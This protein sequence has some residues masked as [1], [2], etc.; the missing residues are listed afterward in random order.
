[1]QQRHLEPIVL[2]T[3]DVVQKHPAFFGLAHYVVVPGVVS[4]VFLHQ[5][6]HRCDF[7]RI[8][9]RAPTV[10]P[11]QPECQHGQQT[12]P[13]V[14]NREPVLPARHRIRCQGFDGLCQRGRQSRK[15]GP[16][17]IVGVA[18]RLQVV[19]RVKVVGKEVGHIREQVGR[20]NQ[21]HFVAVCSVWCQAIE[22][23]DV[24]IPFQAMEPFAQS[25][26]DQSVDAVA[27]GITDLEPGLLRH[28]SIHLGRI[29]GGK[30]AGQD[31]ALNLVGVGA[32]GQ[33]ALQNRADA[34][35]LQAGF[36]RDVD[37]QG[38]GHGFSHAGRARSVSG[39]PPAAV[40]LVTAVGPDR[41]PGGRP[42]A[43]WMAGLAKTA[44]TSPMPQHR[45]WPRTVAAMLC[46][47]HP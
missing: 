28:D 15:A 26:R 36:V 41:V 10:S 7:V 20:V 46:A 30:R 11:L 31:G 4:F 35:D 27:T 3:E 24:Q 40:Q 34:A 33:Q 44:D 39:N 9:D 42:D 16:L 43:A 22:D 37:N 2:G 21:Q 29:P 13:V 45:P 38:Q 8:V 6:S 47:V 25:R 17:G 32:G 19:V 1:M 14:G 23:V 5:A 12:H 18:V